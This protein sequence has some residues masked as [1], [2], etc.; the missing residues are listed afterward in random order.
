MAPAIVDG[1][2]LF[3]LQKRLL[4]FEFCRVKGVI[5]TDCLRDYYFFSP[6]HLLL[7]F[8]LLDLQL[9]FHQSQY[10]YIGSG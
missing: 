3:E 8:H 9:G 5:F 4:H 10:R 7:F 6:S 1:K 2:L